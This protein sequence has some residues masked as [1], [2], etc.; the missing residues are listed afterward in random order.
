MLKDQWDSVVNANILEGEKFKWDVGI[1][2]IRGPF[3][4]RELENSV[5][6]LVILLG[7]QPKGM[8]LKTW[9]AA[10]FNILR[11]VSLSVQGILIGRTKVFGC[12]R[13]MVALVAHM[14]TL[15]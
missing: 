3:G 10:K 5:P 4:E 14:K 13:K 7:D 12:F 1:Q 6:F 8:D 11:E 2:A 15:G 9:K